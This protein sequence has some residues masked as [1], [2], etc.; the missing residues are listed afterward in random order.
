VFLSNKYLTRG[1]TFPQ[2]IVTVLPY[3]WPCLV[4][5]G[6]KCGIGVLIIYLSTYCL[7]NDSSYD[8]LERMQKEDNSDIC[9][10]KH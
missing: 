5:E 8:E 6:G 10:W 9:T 3:V 2:L 1:L 7:F 4:V